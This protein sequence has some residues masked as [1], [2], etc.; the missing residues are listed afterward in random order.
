MHYRYDCY[1]YRDPDNLIAIDKHDRDKGTCKPKGNCNNGY[2]FIVLFY[3]FYF[4]C[5]A[6]DNGIVISIVVIKTSLYS[7][8][9]IVEIW[10]LP[11]TY[12][13]RGESHD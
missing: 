9:G 6:F 3:I 4:Y 11:I 2:H 13:D 5:I 1:C 10:I 7:R 8:M 12:Y